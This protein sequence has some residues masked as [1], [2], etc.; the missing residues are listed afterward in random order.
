MKKNPI[1]RW[2]RANPGKGRH[3]VTDKGAKKVGDKWEK[4]NKKQDK[5]DN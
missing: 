3:G 4:D 2:A 5:K 1:P